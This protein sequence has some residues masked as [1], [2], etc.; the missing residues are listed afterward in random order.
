MAYN[1]TTWSS[2]T[3]S[4]ASETSS[5][6]L[7][8]A[9]LSGTLTVTGATALNG[10]IGTA[11]TLSNTLTVG[12]N[13]TGHDV[14]FHGDTAGNSLWWNE[15][16]DELILQ[17]YSA[18]IS[19]GD[20]TWTGGAENITSPANGHLEINAGTTLDITAPTV[21]IN[22]SSELNIDGNVDLNGTLDVSSTSQF[23]NTITVGGDDTG[24]DV[25]FY[26]A[27]SGKY[28]LWDE[29]DNALKFADGTG[30]TFGNSEDMTINHTGSGAF[31]T[32]TTGG[33]YLATT[34]SGIA[35]SI[36]HTT[37]ETTVNDNLT[38]TG[39]LKLS[40]NV[41]K[42]SDGGSTITMDTSDNVTIAGDLTV[43]GG[44]I[45]LSG[46]A[47]QITLI[48]NNAAA[49]QI[50]SSGSLDIIK[51]ATN[52]GYAFLEVN[53]DRANAGLGVA[54]IIVDSNGVMTGN[55]TDGY[56]GAIELDPVYTSGSSYTITRH[57]YIKIDNVEL[58]ANAAVTDACLFSFDA[59]AGSHKAV[60]SGSAHPDID[61][62]DAWVKININ[63]TI[64]YIPAY[65][66]KS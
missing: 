61:T 66:D 32:N 35:V 3:L 19:F 48:D 8:N 22:V 62:T 52:D 54:S 31:I 16:H 9:T 17:G 33:L 18:T 26:G 42:A 41:I 13:G 38:V 63:G 44:D 37:S 4:K 55:T 29:S 60:D 25:K 57:N 1:S 6:T 27:T 7:N 5:E 45:D 11:L 24:Y 10:G 23:N 2:D 50:G 21:D 12:E 39:D 14:R 65:T 28:L 40:S 53:G 58:G 34:S 46:E 51:I 20:G 43:G 56:V 64:H 49:L 36:G 47:S 15:S 59:N 30:V